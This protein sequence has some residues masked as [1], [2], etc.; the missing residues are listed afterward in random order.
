METHTPRTVN[1]QQQM[2]VL[3]DVGNAL[4]PQREHNGRKYNGVYVSHFM[5]IG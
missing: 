3:H 2:Q 1:S 5:Y 4:V